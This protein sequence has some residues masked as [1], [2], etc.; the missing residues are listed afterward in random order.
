MLS[1]VLSLC[2]V[3]NTLCLGCSLQLDVKH[4]D[5]DGIHH[6]LL[7]ATGSDTMVCTNLL[8]IFSFFCEFCT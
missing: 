2:I 6:V 3:S 5:D 7:F 4:I 1:N 8:Y